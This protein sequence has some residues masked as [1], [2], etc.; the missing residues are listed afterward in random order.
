MRETPCSS[1]FSGFLSPSSAENSLTSA[2]AASGPCAERKNW[3]IVPRLI[4]IGKTSPLCVVYTRW[5]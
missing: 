3:L 1:R 2:R 4:G 5:T